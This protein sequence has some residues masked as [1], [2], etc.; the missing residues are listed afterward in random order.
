MDAN[1]VNPWVAL[2]YLIAGVCFILALRGLSSPASSRRGNR[3]GMAGMAIAVVTTLVTH[4]PSINI[5]PTPGLPA[6][7]TSVLD[8]TAIA[9]ILI[10]IVIGGT[11]LGRA[12]C[13][14]RVGLYV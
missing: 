1:S 5:F 2:A 6:Y 3:F 8:F 4:V 11:K 7:D 9:E 14:E 13:R 12:S 10:P